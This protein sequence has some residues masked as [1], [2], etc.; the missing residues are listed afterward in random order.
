M[1]FRQLAEGM[2]ILA[3]YLPKGEDTQFGGADRDVLFVAP[4]SLRPE[5]MFP[6]DAA[7]LKELGFQVSTTYD[8]WIHHVPS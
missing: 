1:T 6:E 7:R 5:T 8:C 2:Q 3:K 4:S